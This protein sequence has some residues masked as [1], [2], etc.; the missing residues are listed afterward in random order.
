LGFS[1]TVEEVAKISLV[2]G[3]VVGEIK[4]AE[5][6]RDCNCLTYIINGPT[7]GMKSTYVENFIDFTGAK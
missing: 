5:F 2:Y 7:T 1:L 6:L 4:F 3:D